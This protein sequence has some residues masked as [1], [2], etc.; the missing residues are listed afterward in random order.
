[1][2][3][4]FSRFGSRACAAAVCAA[5]GVASF[6]FFG[7]ST[8]GYIDTASLFY[9]WSFQWGVM[10]WADPS[11]ETQHGWL[12][13]GMSV[14]LLWRNLRISDFGFRTTRFRISDFG[15]R[16]GGSRLWVKKVGLRKGAGFELRL[17]NWGL[18]IGRIRN[19]QSAIR[20]SKCPLL[21]PAVMAMVGGLV[22]HGLGFTAQQARISIL[23]LLLFAWGVLRLGGGRRWGAAAAFPLAFMVFAIPVSALDSIGFWLRVWVVDASGAI[24]RAVGIGVL[25][26]GTQLLAPDGTYNYDVAAACSGIRSLTAMAALSLLAG[27]LNFHTW[28]R[29][30]LILALCFP[31]VYIGNVSRILAIIFAAEAGGP[32]WGDIAHEVM[33]YGIFAIVLGGALGAVSLLRRWSPE[34]DVPSEAEPATVVETERTAEGAGLTGSRSAF[35]AAGRR[36]HF[37]AMATRTSVWATAGGVV[38]LA[39]AEMLFLHKVATAPPRGEVGI[40]VAPGGV[41]PAELPAFIGTEWMGRRAEVTAVEREILPPDTGFSRKT[42]VAVGDPKQQVFL[43]IVLS[44]RDRTSIHRP[45]LCLVGQ[46]WTI[47]DAGEHQFRYPVN[48]DASF[49]ARLLRVRREVQTPR[50]KTVVPQ[51]VV[52]WFVGGD[53]IESTHWRRL[54]RDAWNRVVHARADR[55]A[56]VLMQTDAADGE[57]AAL[58]RMQAVL[59]ATLPAFQ[60]PVRV[61]NNVSK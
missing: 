46:G 25:Q 51:L 54:A 52:Y 16:I 29:R 44:G 6:H 33:G 27:Y 43:S 34:A 42:Y 2:L 35:S 61:T 24:A 30:A 9:W 47:V 45:E 8:R 18:W 21:W 32:K 5:A 10:P 13:L 41:D 49:R 1:M 56:Y 4:N 50:G 17:R 3:D 38:F 53:A 55:W 36:C 12:V 57:T 14:W 15:L 31:L 11:S 23:G 39:G 37:E 19:P 58:Q 22:L 26:S 40:A 7:N 20:N 59:D 48:R 60:K 28:W